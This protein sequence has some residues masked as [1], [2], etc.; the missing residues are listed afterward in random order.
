VATAADARQVVAAG[1]QL[2]LVGSAL[3]QAQGPQALAGEVLAADERRLRPGPLRCGSR[4]A[5]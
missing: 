2:A 5:A 4:S 1:Y 3:M